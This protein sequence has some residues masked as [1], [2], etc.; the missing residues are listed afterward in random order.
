MPWWS[1]SPWSGGGGRM[2]M[3]LRRWVVEEAQGW[4]LV[5]PWWPIVLGAVA[6]AEWRRGYDGGLS[7]RQ[8]W[9]LGETGPRGRGDEAAGW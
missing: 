9:G 1:R 6:L 5:V 7:R 3:G 8:G 2:E 4:G